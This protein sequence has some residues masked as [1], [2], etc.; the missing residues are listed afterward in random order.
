MSDAGVASILALEDRRIESL[1]AAKW[2][3]EDNGDA[4]VESY[5]KAQ[6]V[7]ERVTEQMRVW[8]PETA[9]AG[10][11]QLLREVR[12][13]LGQ[14]TT[15]DQAAQPDMPAST[16]QSSGSIAATG[17][18]AERQM[19]RRALI[20]VLFDWSWLITLLVAAIAV[21]AI[22]YKTEFLDSD[23]FQDDTNN[24]WTLAAWAFAI[25]LAGTTVAEAAGRLVTSRSPAVSPP[26]G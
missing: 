23:T 24:Y 4:I 7:F 2:P 20:E 18:A 3:W 26:A 14:A 11:T 10:A 12:R 5:T 9:H 21:T 22:G 1:R 13:D 8:T 25:Q 15:D 16:G 6:D 19:R 17:R